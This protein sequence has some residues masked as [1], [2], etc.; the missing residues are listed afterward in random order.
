MKSGNLNLLE[1]SGPVQACNG[2]ALFYL[3]E[4]IKLY[5]RVNRATAGHSESNETPWCSSFTTP[6]CTTPA[7]LSLAY[8]SESPAYAMFVARLHLTATCSTVLSP[9]LATDYLRNISRYHEFSV[10]CVISPEEC[11]SI[12]DR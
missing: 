7:I 12:S 1:P 10:L 6:L 11:V 2:I 8:S 3:W 4:Q 5:L 9:D